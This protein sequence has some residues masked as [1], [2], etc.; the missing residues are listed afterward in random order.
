MSLKIRVS[1]RF[2][3]NAPL[4]QRNAWLGIELTATQLGQHYRID[5][6]KS[7]PFLKRLVAS[8]I[9]FLRN[10]EPTLYFAVSKSD[11]LAKLGLN[12]SE[13]R[14][15]WSDNQHLLFADAHFFY[16]PVVACERIAESVRATQ[17]PRLKPIRA[18]ETD[19]PWVH[20]LRTMVIG[21]SAI[22]RLIADEMQKGG[23][24]EAA[25]E[26]AVISLEEDMFRSGS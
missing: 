1:D 16:I 9:R 23:S 13:A 3:V 18:A 8:I 2:D 24:R 20:R 14:A 10:K 26:R 17:E 4:L 21:D 22:D 19:G 6:V 11:A 5:L 25:A 12:D 15:W 7:L